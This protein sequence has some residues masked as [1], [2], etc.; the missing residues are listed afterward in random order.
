VVLI[1]FLQ[2]S[3]QQVAAEVTAA[4]LRQLAEPMADQAVVTTTLAPQMLLLAALT[5]VLVVQLVQ[6]AVARI[7]RLVV[8][9]VLVK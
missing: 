8:A 1:Q 4:I 5:K 2:P 6:A 7:M 9:A 3:H